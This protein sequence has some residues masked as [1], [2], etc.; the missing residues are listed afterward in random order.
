M[1][2]ELAAVE[3]GIG[4]PA[5]STIDAAAAAISE[6]SRCFTNGRGSEPC[7]TD[8][9]EVLGRKEDEDGEAERP[10]RG[11]QEMAEHADEGDYLSSL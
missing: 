1:P 4:E 7:A 5:F 9:T 6:D 2:A 10:M 3:V 8:K 11:D